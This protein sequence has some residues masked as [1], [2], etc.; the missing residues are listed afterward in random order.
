MFCTESC[1]H[2]MNA[3]SSGRVLGQCKSSARMQQEPVQLGQ[4]GQLGQTLCLP[5][6]P[7]CSMGCVPV[8]VPNF[9]LANDLESPRL[10]MCFVTE[11]PEGL[12]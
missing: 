9:W 8:P 3:T 12:R 5:Q 7:S 2:G 4:V 1:E 6:Q 11:R 10:G